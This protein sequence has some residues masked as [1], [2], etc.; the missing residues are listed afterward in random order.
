[1]NIEKLALEV[2]K[3]VDPDDRYLPYDSAVIEF[4]TRFLSRY[5]AEESKDAVCELQRTAPPVIY[6]QVSEDEESLNEPFPSWARDE[7][8]WSSISMVSSEVKYV[9]SDL[10]QQPAIPEGYAL[11]PIELSNSAQ[12]AMFLEAGVTVLEI[13]P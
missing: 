13:A 10:R 4:A 3:E 2:A 9:R 5:L 7:V 6:L 12:T 11:V 8:M 1:M